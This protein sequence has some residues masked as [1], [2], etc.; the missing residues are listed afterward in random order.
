M[1]NSIGLF[2]TVTGLQAEVSLF[3]NLGSA[4]NETKFLNIV[5]SKSSDILEHISDEQKIIEDIYLPSSLGE[6][7]NQAVLKMFT[8][9]LVPFGLDETLLQGIQ[10]IGEGAKVGRDAGNIFANAICNFLGL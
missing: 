8:D 10:G 3:R 9:S 5:N 2:G 7:T 1:A 6:D 4:S